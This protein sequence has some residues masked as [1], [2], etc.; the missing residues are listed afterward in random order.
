MDHDEPQ[1]CFAV[2]GPG[3]LGLALTD[4]LL[5]CGY[6]LMGVVSRTQAPLPNVP[7]GLVLPTS[8]LTDVPGV[9]FLTV[10]DDHIAEVAGDL[11]VDERHLVV[12]C[13]GS[14]TLGELARAAERGARTACFHPLQAFPRGADRRRFEG[15]T[16]GIDGDDDAFALLAQVASDLGA[17]ALSLSGVDRARYHAAA[18]FSSN[19]V[20]AL[21]QG[22]TDAWTAAG[23]PEGE[24][25]EA[26]LPLMRGALS[27]IEM[28]PLPEALTGPLARGDLATL[29]HHLARLASDPTLR[30]AYADLSLLLT[31]LG[32]P[33]DD[34]LR[35]QLLILL[36][37]TV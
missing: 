9:I 25:K 24:A 12:H 14:R 29:H 21:M 10:P 34:R 18:V 35:A 37:E 16:V 30:R 13:S 20:V 33:E 3:R 6:P 27:A 2:V 17:R 26:L 4:G 5:H 22:A 19:F 15:V 8:A 7:A 36:Q 23:L 32:L 11:P 1:R 31:R 28:R